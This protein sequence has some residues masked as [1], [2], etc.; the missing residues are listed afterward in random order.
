MPRYFFNIRTD[1]GT[2][3][4]EEGISLASVKHAVEEARLA[5][6]EMVAEAV[7]RDEAIDGTAI[8]VFDE[9]HVL[10]E[11]VRLSSMLKI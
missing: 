5:A 1:N 8:D 3:F 11:T 6:R 2:H 7:L 9:H 10:V 4:D